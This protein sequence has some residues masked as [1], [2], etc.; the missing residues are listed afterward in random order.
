MDRRGRG[1]KIHCLE[2]SNPRQAPSQSHRFEFRNLVGWLSVRAWLSPI[3][4]N[5]AR[6]PGRLAYVDPAL[7]LNF[8]SISVKF[9]T[10]DW[11]GLVNFFLL[12]IVGDSH[13]R[14]IV[15]GNDLWCLG[16][17]LSHTKHSCRYPVLL[18]SHP[19]LRSPEQWLSEL[20]HSLWW[21]LHR[22]I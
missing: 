1:G 9:S 11:N 13:I 4:A 8:N 14:V 5:H 10:K 7:P 22:Q 2:S 17:G 19:R 16:L 12:H 20:F 21:N 18:H 15:F 6:Y 3:L